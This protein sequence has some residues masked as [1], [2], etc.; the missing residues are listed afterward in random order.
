MRKPSVKQSPSSIYVTKLIKASERE[1]WKV[2][3]IKFGR[4]LTEKTIPSISKKLKTVSMCKKD[5]KDEEIIT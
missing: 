2:F 1:L 3:A 4:H 5:A